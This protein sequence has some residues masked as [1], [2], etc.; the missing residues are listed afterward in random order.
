MARSRDRITRAV[1]RAVKRGQIT[2]GT[3]SIA[4][5]KTN[6]RV[7]YT[8][9][10]GKRGT[11]D[12]MNAQNGAMSRLRGRRGVRARARVLRDIMRSNAERQ[13]YLSRT[14]PT[15]GVTTNS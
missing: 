8:R 9:V 3:I 7:N 1:D 15:G 12:T 10:G 2:R 13:A 6:Q 5:R 11:I 14:Q 4:H